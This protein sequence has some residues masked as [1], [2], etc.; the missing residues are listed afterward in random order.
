MKRCLLALVAPLAVV[1]VALALVALG[2]ERPDRDRVYTVEEMQA[3]LA[4]DPPAR[5]RRAL[6][7]RGIG[8]FG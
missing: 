3:E 6:R 7:V 4:H 1:L 5:L 8:Q 2:G